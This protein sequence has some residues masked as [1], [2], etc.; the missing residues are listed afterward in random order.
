[1]HRQIKIITLCIAVI[2]LNFRT[3]PLVEAK[4]PTIELKQLKIIPHGK[5]SDISCIANRPIRAHCFLLSHP[6]RFVIDFQ[7]TASKINPQKISLKETP[8]Q[9]IRAGK[10]SHKLRMVFDLAHKPLSRRII[11]FKTHSQHHIIF[12]LT[13]SASDF[14]AKK[15][16]NK[17]NILSAPLKPELHNAVIVIDPGHGGRDPG[18]IGFYGT[19]EKNVVL[20][21]SKDLYQLLQKQSGITP[22]LTRTGNYFLPLRTRLQI[23][24]KDLADIFIAIHAD[25]YRYTHA[26]GASVFAL[27]EH[28]ATS[29]AAR[30]LAQKENYS[31][32]MG[33]VSLEDKSYLLRSVLIDLSQTATIKET[34][35]LGY[36][37]LRSLCHVTRLHTSRLEQ[38]PFV[39]LKS[40]DIPSVLVEVGFLSNHREEKLLRSKIYQM[41]IA[42][43]LEDGIIHYLHTHPPAD[44]VWIKK[45]PAK[46]HIVRKG[47]TLFSI[48]Q[49]YHVSV[50]YLK[51][52]NH[53][54]NSS[55]KT[56]QILNIHL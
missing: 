49:K 17:K 56:G 12:R 34:L 36:S 55:L 43:A 14:H 47:D 2:L 33:G 31:E 8:I 16:A 48:A 27:S 52:L 10:S 11:K 44:T 1:M 6:D 30:W 54:K 42:R 4:T 24:H 39:V 13:F 40:P 15:P 25:A 7:R 26:R 38:A 22:K 20:A 41:R 29:E 21:I 50:N 53:L 18:A 45:M 23:A 5:Q 19:Q 3:I 9:K 28:G 37:L 51:T 32:L 35:P 46:K